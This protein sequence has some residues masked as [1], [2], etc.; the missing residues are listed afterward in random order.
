[1]G[2][3]ETDPTI[4][5]EVLRRSWGTRGRRWS[6]ARVMSPVPQQ[7]SRTTASRGPK[8][9]LSGGRSGRGRSSKVWSFRDHCPN[10]VSA[11][12]RPAAALARLGCRCGLGRHARNPVAAR[13][14]LRAPQ[15][16]D[17]RR[18]TVANS[19]IAAV[20]PVGTSQ[21]IVN[22][23]APGHTTIIVWTDRG[24]TDYAVTV[25]N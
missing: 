1:M 22:R 16:E 25:T 12:C 11:G 4:G 10:P 18:V 8:S 23:K 20:L 19:R 6:R 13:R 2:S 17:V 7:R 14:T 5:A 24:R 3:E 9:I 15:R 21:V